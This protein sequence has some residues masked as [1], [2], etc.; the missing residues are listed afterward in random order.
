MDYLIKLRYKNF[1]NWSLGTS[2]HIKFD[3][4]IGLEVFPIEPEKLDIDSS[5]NPIEVNYFE[6]LAE[7]ADLEF[8]DD[9]VVRVMNWKIEPGEAVQKDHS[10][11]LKSNCQH[12][13]EFLPQ[14]C[15]LENDKTKEEAVNENP[16][17]TT[18]L[19]C[20]Q[21]NVNQ[22]YIMFEKSKI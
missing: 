11:R 18:M 16:S 13:F 14:C 20:T 10:F 12:E 21:R 17:S 19:E 4:S 22:V 8:I 1:S 2:K 5:G 9:N 7:T 3:V 6:E 15:F